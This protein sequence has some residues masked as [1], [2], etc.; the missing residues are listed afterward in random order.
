MLRITGVLALAAI[1]CA[2]GAPAAGEERADRTGAG[3][4]AFTLGR[5]QRELRPGLSQ[6]EVVE[7]LGSPNILTRDA[8]GREAW[9]YDRV[10][11]EVEVSSAGLGIGGAGTGAGGSFAGVVGVHAGKHSEKRRSSQRALTV[12]IR[13][14][15]AGA[16]ESFSW[17]DSR[18]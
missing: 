1:A 14:S 10:S 11:S 15:A 13:F 7:R 6:A 4:T 3:G 12:V 8:A 9:V 17:H 2:S 5:V 18:F 16:V